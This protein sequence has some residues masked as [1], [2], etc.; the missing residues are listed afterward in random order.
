MQKLRIITAFGILI[1]AVGCI[2]SLH[3]IYT[4]KDIVFE[5]SLIGQ[6]AEEGDDEI[7]AFSKGDENAYKFVYTDDKGKQGVFTA[8][9]ARIEGHLFLD[10]F[11]EEPEFE[12]N[13]FYQFHLLPVH[14]FLHVKQ[15]EPRLQMSFPDPD[16][17][18]ELLEEDPGAIRHEVMEDDD[19]GPILTASTQELQAFWLKHLTTEDAFGDYS[20]M[21]RLEPGA[22]KEQS[23][24]P[25]AGDGK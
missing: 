18:K 15:I 7:W 1:L 24:K 10:F 14:T 22:P 3:P 13:A 20:D 8:H 19:A 4:E 11:P 23:D 21:K 2:R 25:D 12:E 6:W 16:W 9:L 17:L 5:P